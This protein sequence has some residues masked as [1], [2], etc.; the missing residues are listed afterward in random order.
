MI[1]YMINKNW[2]TSKEISCPKI[3]DDTSYKKTYNKHKIRMINS[4]DVSKVYEDL[5]IKLE[6]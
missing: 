5:F 3:R 1:A 4:I 2:F 6:D